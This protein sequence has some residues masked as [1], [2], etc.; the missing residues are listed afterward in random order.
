LHGIT[1]DP[2]DDVL[3]AEI[4][5]LFCEIGCGG[6]VGL[7][8]NPRERNYGRLASLIY[9]IVLDGLYVN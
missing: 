2:L 8:Y 3:G 7:V 1:S 9:P 4:K 5:I 6:V